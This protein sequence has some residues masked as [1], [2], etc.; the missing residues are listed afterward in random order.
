VGMA[1]RWSP[2]APHLSVGGAS[3]PALQ[4]AP[5]AL[6]WSSVAQRGGFSTVAAMEPGGATDVCPIMGCTSL[7]PSVAFVGGH[8]IWL[9]HCFYHLM[10]AAA[11]LGQC[12]LPLLAL[13]PLY[14]THILWTC[15]CASVIGE[16]WWCLDPWALVLVQ[17]EH[18]ARC[19]G[20]WFISAR[21]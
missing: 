5:V 6:L 20:R 9:R 15:D 10:S 21:L 7:E 17:R 16:G 18:R 13:L 4:L 8:K 11:V 19:T 3:W 2:V 1:P 12:R 14:L